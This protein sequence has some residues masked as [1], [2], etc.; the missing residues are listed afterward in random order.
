MYELLIKEDMELFAE[1]YFLGFKKDIWKVSCISY[2]NKIEYLVNNHYLFTVHYE[3]KAK[4][5][6]LT[7]GLFYIAITLQKN[8]K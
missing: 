5:S 7:L 8:E 4:K 6:R 2:E 3:Q 1:K